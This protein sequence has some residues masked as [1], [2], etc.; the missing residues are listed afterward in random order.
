MYEEADNIRREA[1]R[2]RA[3]EELLRAKQQ[4]ELELQMAEEMRKQQA[5]QQSKSQPGIGN[6]FGQGPVGNIF[7]NQFQPPP[8]NEVPV[9]QFIN[10]T[11]ITSEDRWKVMDCIANYIDQNIGMP[12]EQA[13]MDFAFPLGV[14]PL[15]E[16]DFYYDSVINCMQLSY[17]KLLSGWIP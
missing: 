1:E 7:G 5:A 16:P 17:T 15:D 12:Y 9:G 13:Y 4:A 11:K 2:K 3:E 8:D 10:L 6:I 14:R